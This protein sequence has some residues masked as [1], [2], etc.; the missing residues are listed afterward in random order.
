MSRGPWTR[1]TRQSR[2]I[3]RDIESNEARKK[4][5]LKKEGFVPRTEAAALLHKKAV[6][7]AD[8]PAH[9]WVHISLEVESREVE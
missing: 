2:E 4:A 7:I 1:A 3:A 9:E 6:E 5:D 8:G